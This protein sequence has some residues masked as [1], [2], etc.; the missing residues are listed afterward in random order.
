MKGERNN[1]KMGTWKECGRKM[2]SR[3]RCIRDEGMGEGK[4]WLS[5]M[6]VGWCAN[7]VEVLILQESTLKGH[8]MV[9]SQLTL[10]IPEH[11]QKNRA[12]ESRQR[13]QNM[14]L[15]G[16]VFWMWPLTFYQYT[17][18]LWFILLY[19]L[20]TFLLTWVCDIY[21]PG[22]ELVGTIITALNSVKYR[23][24]SNFIIYPCCQYYFKLTIFICQ[25]WFMTFILFNS[26]IESV[27]CY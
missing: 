10:H 16:I 27:D 12:V 21:M 15:I 8:H 18:V 13:L 22:G 26:S 25:E 5:V 2:G 14:W 17:F 6:L 24:F 1:D 9:V 19:I 4:T 7:S 20:S 23:T 11:S 3:R